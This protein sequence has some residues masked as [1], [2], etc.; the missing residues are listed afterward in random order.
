MDA[1]REEDQSGTVCYRAT[2]E[3]YLG[4]RRGRIGN[5]GGFKEDQIADY[6]FSAKPAENFF[7]ADGRWASTAEYFE[8]VESG[9]HTLRLKYEASA[10]NLVMAS[11]DAIGGGRRSCR[12]EASTS[13]SG[14]TGHTLSSCGRSQR[15]K[16]RCG[17]LRSNVFSGRQ[18]RVREH[19]LELR[20]TQGVAAFAFTFTSCVDP[21]ASALQGHGAAMKRVVAGTDRARWQIAGL[22]AYSASDH[23]SQ[24]GISQA[25]KLKRENSHATLYAGNLRKNWESSAKSATKSRAF[26]HEYP[27]GGMVELR[28]FDVREF[29]KEIEKPNI[30]R[31]SVGRIQRTCRR[32]ISWKPI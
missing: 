27:N 8:A 17:R 7:Y 1:L 23:A 10:V 4:N 2:G 19:E 16:L 32:S 31:Y 26:S 11:P 21:V 6:S 5:E 24:V 9:L 15:R 22:P 12:W 25:E 29:Q 18:P 20:C 3:L 28:F 13:R 30:Q 14:D